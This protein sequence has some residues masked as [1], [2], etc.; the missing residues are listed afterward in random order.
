MIKFVSY[1]GGSIY[2]TEQARLNSAVSWYRTTTNLFP[3]TPE[4]ARL[5]RFIRHGVLNAQEAS[6]V[7]SKRLKRELFRRYSLMVYYIDDGWD[8]EQSFYFKPVELWPD[9]EKAVENTTLFP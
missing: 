8:T 5:A 3:S 7:L 9:M 6:L 4:I 2:H 1:L